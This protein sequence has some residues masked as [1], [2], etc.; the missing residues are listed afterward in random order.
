[1]QCP[2]CNHAQDDAVIYCASCGMFLGKGSAAAPVVNT[3]RGKQNTTYA[4]FWK[5]FAATIIDSIVVY[6]AVLIFSLVAAAISDQPLF[7]DNGEEMTLTEIVVVIGYMAFIF[8]G[9]L[10]RA[11]MESSSK[12]GT[13]G[14]M[15]LGIVVTDMEGRRIS[16]GRATGRYFAQILSIITFYVGFLMAAWTP[17]KQALHDLAAK[18]LVVNKPTS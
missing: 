1:M 4:G 15:A 13:L 12:Q 9:W 16:F 14:K 10:Y 8:V 7:E 11:V 3:E 2:R 6:L 17:K 5:R 18:T